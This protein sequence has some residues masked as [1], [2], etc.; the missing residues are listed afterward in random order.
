MKSL[1][2]L[3]LTVAAAFAAPADDLISQGDRLD[4]K[5]QNREALE[6][7]LKA[8]SARPNDAEILHRIA[9]QYAQLM[10]DAGAAEKKTLGAKAL[11][12]AQRAIAADPKNANAHL[13]LSI[14][15]GR[16]AFMESPRKRIEMSRKIRDE[17]DIAS[18]LDPKNDVAWLVLGRW[19]YELANF[20]PFLKTIAQTV[21]GKL[22]DASN[23]KALGY[24]EKAV[25]LNPRSVMNQIEL[26]RAYAALGKTS[27]AREAIN[28]GLALPSVA[29]DDEETKQR[30]RAALQ[31]LK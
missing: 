16:I 24:F 8:D 14:I 30:G 10:L 20:N 19:N 9:K 1:A 29:K 21:Y 7:Y 22:P 13:S 18:R 12:A 25:A 23:E 31:K 5:N 26:G 15:Y 28:K 4:A 17:A 6:L 2:I 3:L 27:E 11:D